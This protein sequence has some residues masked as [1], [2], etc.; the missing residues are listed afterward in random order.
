M[1]IETR[2]TAAWHVDQWLNATVPITP[3]ALKGRVVV[4]LA[5]QMLCPGCVAHALPLAMRVHRLFPPQQVA[6]LGL[7]TVFEHHEAMTP[8]ALRAF[9]HE[10]RI[11]FPVG[12]DRAD[13]SG[14]IPRTMRAHAMRGT[15]TWLL[16]DADGALR[17]HTFGDI[18]ALALGA[19]I[20]NLLRETPSPVGASP[21]STDADC[22]GNVCAAP[23]GERHGDV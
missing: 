1:N 13:D 3:T 12:I 4:M 8:L 15:P 23:D 9:L 6:M 10:Y 19:G 18:D 7:H 16:F 22:R 5:F 14:P 21:A 11:A 17:S 2:T 20:A